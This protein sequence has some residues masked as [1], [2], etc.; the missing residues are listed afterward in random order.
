MVVSSAS[1]AAT[2]WVADKVS[3]VSSAPSRVNEADDAA[4]VYFWDADA[5]AFKARRD[6]MRRCG[7]DRAE[8]EAV[9]E[10]LTH[11]ALEGDDRR[12][13]VDCGHYRPGRC[14]AHRRAGLQSA[15]I[16]RTLA[17]LPQRCGGYFPR[18]GMAAAATNPATRLE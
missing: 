16:G 9:A 6:W 13:C 18:P 15:E 11:R 17:A 12:V 8:A 10:R 14:G 3:S 4:R 1:S 7:W 2:P 5:E